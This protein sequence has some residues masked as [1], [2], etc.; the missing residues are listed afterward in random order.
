MHQIRLIIFQYNGET[1][2]IQSVYSYDS[3]YIYLRIT[4]VRTI[5]DFSFCN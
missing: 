3:L 4:F 1:T 2:M 5:L